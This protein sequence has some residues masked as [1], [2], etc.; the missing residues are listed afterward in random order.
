MVKSLADLRSEKSD[1]RPERPYRVF[2]GD[3]QKY[4]AE[5]KRLVEEHDDV[6]TQPPA[7]DGENQPPKMLAKPSIP[8]RAQEIR[9]RLA[10]LA[11]L[12][13]EYEGEL[14]VRA[15]WSDGD[16]KQWCL[17]HPAREEDQPGHR[18]DLM[19]TGGYCNA[20]DLIVAL[21]EFVV[22]WQGEPLAPGDFDALNLL[23]PD[24][25]AIA[26]MVV[27]LY[28]VGED[29]PKWRSGLSAQLKSGIF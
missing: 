14:T 15:S 6:V 17:A 21:P 28:E 16:W 29:V 11:D 1:A 7:G 19:I 18:D 20:E 27:G 23:R 10:E 24:K 12:M 8:P 13:A 3:G 26:S 22:A 25:K 5:S 9:D 2:V 4:V